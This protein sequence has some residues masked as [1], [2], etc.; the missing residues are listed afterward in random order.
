MLRAI[1]DNI[2]LPDGIVAVYTPTYIQYIPS[3][4]RTMSIMD[5]LLPVG[6]LT[7]C[8]EAYAG[9]LI[10]PWKGANSDSENK[11]IQN[12]NRTNTNMK[13]G[14]NPQTSALMH[15]EEDEEI[16][17]FFSQTDNSTISS[18]H[19]ATSKVEVITENEKNIEKSNSLEMMNKLLSRESSSNL[20][21]SATESMHSVELN[22]SVPSTPR[23]RST[24]R[25][26]G[27]QSHSR[28]ESL[29]V[30]PKVP[31]I[32]LPAR[33]DKMRHFAQ[34]PLYKFAKIRIKQDQ[35]LSP[36]Q[37]SDELLAHMPTTYLVGS[38]LDPCLDDS[39]MFAK[40]LDALGVD[41]HLDAAAGVPHGFMNFAPISK[42]CM[43]ATNICKDR[44][45]DCLGL[46]HPKRRA[47]TNLV[48][49]NV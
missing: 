3:P 27:Y 30:A 34:S 23:R 2:R 8:L 20:L 6:I 44:I 15:D 33:H 5:A 9:D 25:R 38:H 10:R 37:A 26:S 40:R 41:V 28:S 48:H 21:D 4:S 29:P 47:P 39:V 42:E 49:N 35:F 45:K 7:T 13:S 22:D 16:Q 19:N 12:N 1:Q 24:H 11:E 14:N 32:E 46:E 43:Q 17:S 31:H 36:L 18:Y